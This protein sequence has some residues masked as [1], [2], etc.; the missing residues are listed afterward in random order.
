[1]IEQFYSPGV[2]LGYLRG[3]PLGPHIDGFASLLWGQGYATETGRWKIHLVSDL[4]AWLDDGHLGVEG[5][6][7]EQTGRFLN[8]RKKQLLLRRGDRRTMAQLLDHLRQTGSI[9]GPCEVVCDNPVDQLTEDYAH[10][11]S[12]QRGLS[13]AT[14]DNY[15]PVAHRFLGTRF[16]AKKVRLDK[17]RVEDVT[18]FIVH[19]SSTGCPKRTQRTASALRSFLGFLTQEGRI[20]ANLAASVP[21]VANWRLSELPR[22]LEPAQI[23]K[24]LGSCD[25]NTEMGRRD[26]AVLLLLARLGLRGGEVVHLSLE[27]INWA[28]GEVLIRGKSARED[29]LPLVAEVGRALADYLQRD[30]PVCS[31]R[32]VF[33]RIKAPHQG[34]SSSSAVCDIVRRALARAELHPQHRGAHLLRRS[35]ATK[36]LRCGASLTQIGQVLRHQLAQTTEIY[37]KVD[38]GALRALAQPWPG[39]GR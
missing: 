25:K 20:T 39:G 27:N 11:L 5:L 26:Y 6:N 36:M 4:S 23:E 13:Q 21:A 7:E 29:R 18:G 34:F 22:F 12:Q 32:R 16:D 3:G 15:L 33:I 19:D 24:L 8:R 2:K 31:C 35:L 9:P 30:R 38:L 17:L 28:A 37:A 10:F 14:I 1:M